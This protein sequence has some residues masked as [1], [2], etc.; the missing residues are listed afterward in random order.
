MHE[1]YQDPDLKKVWTD[2]R[3]FQEWL[4]VEIAVLIARE[5]LG[6]I[7]AGTAARVDERTFVDDGAAALIK[8]RD[9]VTKHDLVA[10]KQVMDLQLI[11]Q[12]ED[13]D[14]WDT[15]QTWMLQIE[16]ETPDAKEREKRFQ[17]KVSAVLRTPCPEAEL[18]HDGL[19]SYD[20]EEPAMALLLLEAC[21]VVHARL[22]LL[23][24]ALVG[25][26]RKLRG[27]LMIG[28]THG[29]YAQP[30]TGGVKALNWLE[31]IRLAKRRLAE[32]MEE[33]RVM[34]LSGAVGMYGTLGPQVEDAVAGILSL[35]PVI[36][37]QIL[38]LGRRAQLVNTLAEVATE[39]G[40]IAHD[41]WLMAQ[42]E[43][44]EVREPFDKEQTGSSAMPHKKNPITL[45]QL[46]G[47]PRLVRGAAQ[48]MLEN[49]D[50]H[51]ERDISQSSV[52]RNAVPDAFH[53]T[54]HLA[55]R[56]T[57]VLNGMEVFPE[58]MR[59]NLD[60]TWGTYASQAVERFLKERGMPAET[61]YRL[62]Q[63][64]CFLAVTK[65][66]HLIEVLRG[67]PEVRDLADASSQDFQD[68]FEP[69]L[70]VRYEADVYRRFD[71]YWTK[72]GRLS[73]LADG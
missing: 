56:L 34:K 54:A 66:A 49:V 60:R 1:R 5:K 17:A 61:A 65:E 11:L 23:D 9:K 6:Q 4:R 29:Q 68:L 28:R 18:F 3:K 20:V 22:A 71:A 67:W 30:I 14:F 73:V 37:T 26:A 15:T 21:G 63:E 16:A 2:T 44:G 40:K 32:A 10:F 62:V 46:T 7:P 51:H 59:R 64:A 58:K 43:V 50:T 70:W 69:R 45:E 35:K 39:I 55:R 25:L 53:A 24:A 12:Q 57:D 48:A 8:R 41:L 42:S 13:R 19:T 33:V 31:A 36:A 72:T 47:L 27:V 38:G 52:E